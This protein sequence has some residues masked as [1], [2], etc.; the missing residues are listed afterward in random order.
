VVVRDHHNIPSYGISCEK[1]CEYARNYG[2]T[3]SYSE[4][5]KVKETWLNWLTEYPEIRKLVSAA[6]ESDKEGLL[7]TEPL[8]ESET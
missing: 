6:P 7:T 2:R 1:F 3:P 4:A 5:L 8:P